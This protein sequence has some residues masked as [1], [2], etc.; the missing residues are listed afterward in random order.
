MLEEPGAGLL[1]GLGVFLGTQSFALRALLGCLAAAL[2]AATLVRLHVVRSPRARRLVILAPIGTA[3]V[4]AAASVGEEFLPRVLVAGGAGEVI[5]I[6]GFEVAQRPLDI[7]LIA[8]AA[9]AAFLVL[10]RFLGLVAV[11]RLL[12][13]AVPLRDPEMVGSARRLAATMEVRAPRLSTLPHCPGGAFAFGTRRPRVA[14]DPELFATLDRKELE[15]L[16]AHEIAH[17][18]R[19][20]GSL[21]LAVGLVRDLTF[22]LPP[23]HTA[24]RWLR[25]EQ[26]EGAD[27]LACK[28]TRRPAALASSILKVWDSREGRVGAAVCATM[29]PA[30]ALVRQRD[31]PW[32]R[33]PLE[34]ASS[35]IAARVELLIDR[36]PAVGA[37]R[38]RAEV[39]L[40]LA[41]AATAGAAA[42]AGPGLLPLQ[43]DLVLGYYSLPTPTGQV[44]SPSFATFRASTLPLE[45]SPATAEHAAAATEVCGDCLLVESTAQLFNRDPAS[46][47]PR[48]EG[49]EADSGYRPWVGPAQDPQAPS[50]E[51]LW[52]LDRPNAQIGFF[53][54]SDRPSES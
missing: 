39:L 47:P 17:L 26:E 18:A 49:W 8:Y 54:V 34:R 24:V 14:I 53:L 27:A 50:A 44:E 51:P 36:P 20:D 3:V 4:A 43:G 31:L 42:V 46:A 1:N 10:R 9:V 45:M 41:V 19:R 15:G 28:H 13:E 22:F 40:A 12:R 38:G 16:L 11:R 37:W 35:A 25:R 29:T 48:A 33:G 5:Q 6:M 32:R 52:G 30:V 2:L 23:L 7:L 21:G